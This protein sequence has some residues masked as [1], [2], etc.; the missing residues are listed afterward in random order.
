MIVIV[1]PHRMRVVALLVVSLGLVGFT[2]SNR[3]V[4]LPLLSQSLSGPIV[5]AL[6]TSCAACYPLLSVAP[7]VERTLVRARQLRV[8]LVIGSLALAGVGWAPLLARST[9]RIPLISITG[10]CLLLA[11]GW[12]LIMV[13]GDV[14][15]LVTA[16]L[17][18]A[19]LASTVTPDLP[20]ARLLENVPP[21]GAVAGLLLCGAS[22][23]WWGTKESRARSGT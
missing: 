1:G 4:E 2:T 23:V 8:I 12:L 10:F 14:G 13:L 18:M 22:Y 7:E 15:L 20:A 3:Y 9:M 6:V 21:V 17:D 11:A 5:T 16:T 19:I